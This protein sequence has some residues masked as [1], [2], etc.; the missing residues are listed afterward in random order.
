MA[1]IRIGRLTLLGET[2]SI[3]GGVIAIDGEVLTEGQNDK[4]HAAGPLRVTVVDGILT[5]FTS[6]S[7]IE[8][9][10]TVQKTVLTQ[11]KA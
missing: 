7:P 4:A 6:D 11:R 10:G 3:Q 1:Q 9:S 5:R 8:I 2:I